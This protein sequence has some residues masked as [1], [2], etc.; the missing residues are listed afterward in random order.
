MTLQ[1]GGQPLTQLDQLSPGAR[2]VMEFVRGGPEWLEWAAAETV[3]EH[4]AFAGEAALVEAVQAG[5]HDT[6]VVLLSE[7]GLQVDVR[8]LWQLSPE[9]L[10]V[11]AGNVR[12]DGRPTVKQRKALAANRLWTSEE[13]EKATALLTEM[14]VA[15]E[16]VFQAMSL[17]DRVAVRGLTESTA[18]AGAAKLAVDQAVS[19]REFVD[20]YRFYMLVSEQLPGRSSVESRRSRAEEIRGIVEP[21]VRPLLRCP[22]A[23]S[24]LSAAQAAALVQEW[25]E[26]GRALGF[27]RLSHGL[28]EIVGFAGVD[29]SDS[30]AAERA[31]ES[32]AEALNPLLQGEPDSEELT[33]DGSNQQFRWHGGDGSSAVLAHSRSA[34][35]LA[36]ESFEQGHAE[37]TERKE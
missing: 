1:V 8:R 23:P 11:V 2:Q 32:Y 31:I 9:S 5:L 25:L 34:G 15:S 16:P 29:I 12:K 17:G 36:I 19:P 3:P 24:D 14:G 10:E 33:Q 6:S 37:A 21:A 13:L 27:S 20:Y 7:L 22:H 30:A 18:S 35:I 28:R 4:F 26:T